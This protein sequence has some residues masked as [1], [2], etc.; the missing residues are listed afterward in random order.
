MILR[1]L[2]ISVTIPIIVFAAINISIF[3]IAIVF[4]MFDKFKYCTYFRW[5]DKQ[6]TKGYK[7]IIFRI[8]KKNKQT[9]K[10]CGII[11]DDTNE[12]YLIQTGP[13]ARKKW[14][15]K[16]DLIIIVILI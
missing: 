9:A 3:A 8:I 13:F 1:S 4:A 2:F 12:Q 6:K 7:E 14:I 11:F 16:K 10:R 15:N 5:A